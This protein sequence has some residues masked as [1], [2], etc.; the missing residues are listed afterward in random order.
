MKNHLNNCPKCNSQLKVTQYSCQDC[1]SR[2]E[3]DFTGCSFCNLGDDDRLFALV[4]LQT[5]GNMKDVERVLGISYPTVKSR[6]A[7]LNKALAGETSFL[8]VKS[9]PV[10]QPEINIPSEDERAAILNRLA[11]GEITAKEAASLLRGDNIKT[12]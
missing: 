7:K 10:D 5:E 12:E 2:V 9:E 3:G 11:S 8:P 4:F 6:L 1:G